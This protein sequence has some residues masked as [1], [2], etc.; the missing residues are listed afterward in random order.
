MSI[1][2]SLDNYSCNLCRYCNRSPTF[3][4]RDACRRCG[5]AMFSSDAINLYP[6]PYV[7]GSTYSPFNYGF[8]YPFNYQTQSPYR[9]SSGRVVYYNYPRTTN[10]YYPSRYSWGNWW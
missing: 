5:T 10:T 2:P 1:S 6:Q 7:Y 3:A 4:C 8:N 9:R